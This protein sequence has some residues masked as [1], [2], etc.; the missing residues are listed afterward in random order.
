MKGPH[1]FLVLL[2][3]VLL[4]CLVFGL[5]KIQ[6]KA[7]KQRTRRGQTAVE[8]FVSDF[9]E[10]LDNYCSQIDSD[11][12]NYV[13]KWDNENKPFCA[14][15]TC[16]I[17]ECHALVDVG[18]TKYGIRNGVVYEY[19]AKRSPMKMNSTPNGAGECVSKDNPNR[20][21]YCTTTPPEA[22]N[23]QDI[24][25]YRF[26]SEIRKWVPVYCNYYYD[27][28][29]NK[30][31]RNVDNLVEEVSVYSLADG[32]E[33]L[34]EGKGDGSTTKL[35]TAKGPSCTLVDNGGGWI[36]D[37]A[38]NNVF[39]K[40][41]S[42]N[43]INPDM[44]ALNCLNNTYRRFG[45]KDDT[46]FQCDFMDDSCETCPNQKSECYAFD[47][48]SRM[49]EPV[50]YLSTVY[51]GECDTYKIN[52]DK[53]EDFK[54]RDV[55]AFASMSDSMKGSFLLQ[56]DGNVSVKEAN[57]CSNSVPQPVCNQN[58]LHAC[59]YLNE[60]TMEFDT[61]T[62]K[63]LNKAG[64]RNGCE[65]CVVGVGD[66]NVQTGED[67]A[68]VL[69]SANEVS[70]YA[71]L[72]DNVTK[73]T[74]ACPI[75]SCPVGKKMVMNDQNLSEP[76]RCE[77]CSP[78]EY[79]DRTGGTCKLLTSCG[80][81]NY[82][83]DAQVEYLKNGNT[84]RTTMHDYMSNVQ[85]A[86]GSI[87]LSDVRCRS[88]P[89]NT[90]M[91]QVSHRETGCENCDE[92]SSAPAGSASCVVCPDNKYR[93]KDMT[94]CAVCPNDGEVPNVDKDGC[95]NCFE[96]EEVPNEEG[97]VCRP[98]GSGMVFENNGCRTECRNNEE[99]DGTS[100]KPVQSGNKV[101]YTQTPVGRRRR[102]VSCPHHTYRTEDMNKLNCASCGSV[103]SSINHGMYSGSGASECSSCSSTEYWK[104]SNMAG[105][106]VGECAPCDGVVTEDENGR[107]TICE[108][109]DF[110]DVYVNTPTGTKESQQSR[111]QAS[112]GACVCPEGTHNMNGTCVRCD[113]VH[114]WDGSSCVSCGE[115]QVKVTNEDGTEEC[116]NCEAHHYR[117][118]ND[119]ECKP[120]TDFETGNG[121]KYYSKPGCSECTKCSD[122]SYWD[123]TMGCSTC[124]DGKTGS[125]GE[126]VASCADCPEHTY[127]DG[128]MAA[129]ASCSPGYAHG[130]GN[131]V[132][133][134]CPNGEYFDNTVYNQMTGATGS[135]VSMACDF[136]RGEYFNNATSSCSAT[137]CTGNQVVNATKDGC[138]DCPENASPDPNDRRRCVCDDPKAVWD[139]VQR[140][141]TTC[142]EGYVFKN[143][144]CTPCPNVLSAYVQNNECHVCGENTVP[145]ANQTDCVCAPN[146]QNL[147]LTELEFGMTTR[148]CVECDPKQ[149]KV[150]DDYNSC[151]LCSTDQY[152]NPQT[153]E[154]EICPNKGEIPD[155]NDRTKCICDVA[156]RY[157]TDEVT[158]ECKLCDTTV[159]GTS[160]DGSKCNVENCDGKGYF[161]MNGVCVECGEGSKPDYPTNASSC[162]C[163]VLNDGNTYDQHHKQGFS[164]FD[165][166][167]VKCNSTQHYYYNGTDGCERCEPRSNRQWH[168]TNKDCVE[169]MGNT[170]MKYDDMSKPYCE[171]CP[172]GTIPNDDHTQ[173]VCDEANHYKPHDNGGCSAA[174]CEATNKQYWSGTECV[175]CKDK[176]VVNDTQTSCV[177][178]P[179]RP[180]YTVGFKDIY[181]PQEGCIECD[182][183]I[184]QSVDNSSTPATCTTGCVSS[185]VKYYNGSECITCPN[186]DGNSRSVVLG[187]GNPKRC[188]CPQDVTSAGIYQKNYNYVDGKGCV[189]C[190]TTN[191]EYLVE[192]RD[193][194]E[195]CPQ[196][197]RYDIDQDNCV[198]DES[199][200]YY[201]NSSDTCILCDTTQ[202]QYFDGEQCEPCGA[203]EQVKYT[204]DGCECKD[205]FVRRVG[206][207]KCVPPDNDFCKDMNTNPN[208]CYIRVGNECKLLANSR[209]VEDRCVCNNGYGWNGTECAIC[210][211]ATTVNGRC[212]T[213]H[214]AA[215]GVAYVANNICTSC[216]DAGY[217]KNGVC[218]T[219]MESDNLKRVKVGGKFECDCRSDDPGNNRFYRMN[220]S[221]KKCVVCT[222]V[223]MK[224][225]DGVCK[226]GESGY[227][228]VEV[229]GVQK[230]RPTN[231]NAVTDEFR[232]Q[233]FAGF[234]ES[235]QFNT[236]SVDSVFNIFLDK[237]R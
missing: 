42:V 170:V 234:A 222:D 183:S 174:P 139:S 113:S 37:D 151:T 166:G 198:C 86:G 26:D 211:N 144:E 23:A 182:T 162:V 189:K 80:E 158:G 126:G 210:N 103:L 138:V 21:V 3:S 232:K 185:D 36:Q 184:G 133:T 25:A 40:T 229:N 142:P 148:S 163:D 29:G 82:V 39:E 149:G 236:H 217:V 165:G 57:S 18:P 89:E 44:N 187:S 54:S 218:T 81:G 213:C 67:K 191:N 132:C 14:K 192:S 124:P 159:T 121:D 169:C 167:C 87:L 79:Y 65:Y 4:V 160:W 201:A 196:N 9:D 228:Q 62:Y 215:E 154:C 12:D 28:T 212:T 214:G 10:V 176:S 66:T 123:S 150:F 32:T 49:W 231:E 188:G 83:E 8:G 205:G 219:C 34:V 13:G 114:A 55:S 156:N 237:A 71:S 173:C 2:C 152:V 193:S 171:T 202:N 104:E 93:S 221:T 134:S 31:L 73:A 56:R 200:K 7:K 91:N 194:C 128:E 59:K 125:R 38:G 181:N 207:N 233:G 94:G 98:C 90:Y 216:G 75:A 76:L 50:H 16:Q 88:C 6:K 69:A 85:P 102:V 168:P 74:D 220:N 5:G 19:I 60:D 70:R 197:R 92:G 208:Q 175:T 223:N 108:Q 186:Q 30:V 97:T 153:N 209:M 199:K 17:E 131:S 118:E 51:Q 105:K 43:S 146:K 116:K 68:C 11:A 137:L 157:L 33:K 78:N 52:P 203:N 46:G 47:D 130:V 235:S 224:V 27:S 58:R 95:T 77:D 190:N 206:D 110:V 141:C 100:C 63:Q 120:C 164:N 101:E 20:N 111:K 24:A 147:H 177:C 72:S 112:Q 195:K 53:N 179:A 178:E 226:C 230:C 64:G 99:F 115:G 127:R 96:N 140:K 119:T 22:K 35:Y 227:V 172:T 61:V 122:N 48:T 117:A 45:Y 180:G 145:N 106:W 155:L 15:S 143:G 161:N 41:Q 107:R 1:L 129:C 136:M 204:K 109:C 225:V 135:C 84:V